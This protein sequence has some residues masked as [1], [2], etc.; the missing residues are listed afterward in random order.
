M[1]IDLPKP[2]YATSN[3][4]LVG[5]SDQGG[6]CD[7]VQIMVHNGYAYVAHIFSKG[8]S[9]IDVRDP[10]H[11]AFVKYIAAPP[12]TWTL[13]LQ[14]D[15]ADTW[16]TRAVE[17]GCTVKMAIAD[18]FWGDRYGAVIDPFGHSWSIGSRLAQSAPPA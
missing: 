18:Q 15:N 17:A 5:H 7:A 14:V 10:S 1:S 13:H 2:D 9:V 11:P 6:R 3:M 16:Y 12:N 8:F 4:R